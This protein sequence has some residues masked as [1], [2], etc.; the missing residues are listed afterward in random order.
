MYR[1]SVTG[2]S[3]PKVTK[4][5]LLEGWALARRVSW[6]STAACTPCGHNK[7]MALQ[8]WLMNNVMIASVCSCV[9]FGSVV[10]TCLGL[11]KYDS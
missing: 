4:A 2:T 9:V 8:D 6:W 11:G 3:S 5:I 1:W 10:D 7:G